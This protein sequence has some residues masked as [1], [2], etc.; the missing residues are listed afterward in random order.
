MLG[1]TRVVS[2][3]RRQGGRGV[4]EMIIVG[5]FC[6]AKSGLFMRPIYQQNYPSFEGN[7]EVKR[8]LIPTVTQGF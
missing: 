8:A 4:L 6:V 5:H 7:D 1:E 2:I 3:F